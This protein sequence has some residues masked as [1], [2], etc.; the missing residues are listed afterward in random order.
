MYTYIEDEDFQQATP[1][2]CPNCGLVATYTGTCHYCGEK[3]E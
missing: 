1:M 2:N 3:C